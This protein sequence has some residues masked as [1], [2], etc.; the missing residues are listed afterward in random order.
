MKIRKMKLA[1][2][3]S[4][5]IGIL[6]M[7]MLLGLTLFSVNIS[8]QAIMPPIHGE[9]TGIAA[10]NG[11]M[12]QAV[13][14]E[15][16][17]V[18]KDLQDYMQS[19]YEAYSKITDEE[20]V[21][22]KQSV[23]YHTDIQEIHYNVEN[24]ILNTAWSSLKRNPDIIGVGA[25]FEPSAFDTAISGYSLYISSED[26]NSRKAKSLGAYSN[27]CAN[28]Y[29]ATAKET[30]QSSITKPYK[31]NGTMLCTVSVPI[32][33]KDNVQG[34]IVVDINIA[35]FA[36]VKS[37]D[38]KYPTM[39]VD[40]YTQDNTIVYDSESSDFVGDNMETLLPA[41][42]YEKITAKQ[43]AG[44]A[45]YVNTLRDTGEKVSRFYYPVDCG[46]ET[47]WA[48]SVLQESDLNKDVKT[49]TIWMLS[50]AAIVLLIVIIVTSV[51]LRKLINPIQSVLNAANDIA[52]GNL[53]I[54]VDV[55]SEDEIGQLAR[56][57]IDMSANLKSIISDIHYLLGAMADG[58]FEIKSECPEKYVGEFS[59][60][61]TAIRGI[62]NN[63][64]NTLLQ[65]NQASD[66][67][68]S[69]SDQVSSGA[70][71]LSQGATEQ[72]SAIQELSASIAEVSD[73]IKKNAENAQSANNLSNETSTEVE[74]GNHHMQNMIAAMD[75][76]SN[77]S[78]EIGKIIRTI[79]DI[80]FQ[81]NILAL[82]A[83]VEA[84]R[85][86]E[87][88]K[89]F[90]V[91]ADEVRNLAGK[92]AE[93]AKNTTVLIEGAVT[94]IENGTK[95]ADKTA[96]SLGVIVEKVSA[97]A[98]NINDIATASE[99]QAEAISQVTLGVEQISS[100]VQTN[101]ATAE[102]SAAASE[103]LSGQAQ[104]LKDLVGSFKLAESYENNKNDFLEEDSLELAQETAEYFDE[105]SKY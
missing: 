84:A 6:L 12:V 79:D 33:Y 30:K 93:A 80:A 86:G 43:A 15:A 2:K 31:F 36:K 13:I 70:Q 88:G 52:Q 10:E 26:A 20:K 81:T 72:A 38:E 29:Y 58:D 45:F 32:L 55:K 60:I 87:A 68:S 18:A 105:S 82:N 98:N 48:S 14:D 77:A 89:G 41:S 83:A 37:T 94:A 103:E 9:F 96:K 23:V 8:K 74:T 50:I 71:A 64:S 56:T 51:M 3:T 69:G 7:V 16:A 42:E 78:N 27:Y 47:W 17:G 35:N 19:S 24:Y 57:F 28:D 92:S 39:Y 21:V 99:R 66:Q 101:S 59:E 90:A 5:V 25:L 40:I 85:A 53:D 102:E 97:V 49:L 62:N 22:K 75:E 61:R 67:V 100:V 1:A 76:I 44:E 104:M 46:S 4:I 11:L 65:I 95:T 34:V 54:N 91:V 73:H 63:L